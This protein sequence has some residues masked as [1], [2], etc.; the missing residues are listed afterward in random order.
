MRIGSAS[1]ARN[2]SKPKSKAP[3]VPC[4]GVSV[5]EVSIVSTLEDSEGDCVDSGW[6]KE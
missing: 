2:G 4:M 5:G 3:K 1:A 6:R